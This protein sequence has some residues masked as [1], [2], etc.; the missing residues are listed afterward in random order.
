[1]SSNKSGVGTDKTPENLKTLNQ[2]YKLYF[3]HVKS[4]DRDRSTVI[5]TPMNKA[6][7]GESPSIY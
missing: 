3:P 4:G 7:I 1:M 5:D 2:E 6:G